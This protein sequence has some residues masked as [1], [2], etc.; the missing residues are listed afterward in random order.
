VQL[1]EAAVAAGVATGYY[2]IWGTWRE[3]PHDTLVAALDALGYAGAPDSVAMAR[4]VEERLNERAERLLPELIVAEAGTAI[5]MTLSPRCAAS[6]GRGTGAGFTCHWQVE[7]EAGGA[8]DG[9]CTVVGDQIELPSL[10][11]GQHR[12]RVRL[13]AA[14]PTEARPGASGAPG[15]DIASCD[16]GLLVAPPRCYLPEFL[17][18]GGRQ[19]GIAVQLYGLRSE[20]NWGIGDLTDLIA[21]IDAAVALGAQVVG[22][23]PLHALAL[24][25]PES[26]SPYSAVSRLFLHPLYIDPERCSGFS[27]PGKVEAICARLAPYPRRAS[28]RQE[29]RVDYAGVSGL[30]LPVLRALFEAFM[31]DEAGSDAAEAFRQFQHG[32]VGL[33]EHATFQSIQ[34]ALNAA[35][36]SVWG[37]PCWP[38]ALQDPGSAQVLAWQRDHAPDIAF[39]M[40][41]EWQARQQWARV[42]EHARAAQVAL[43]G[44]L[45]LGADRGGSEVWAAQA[46]HAL[47]M[48]AGCPPDD[49]NLQGQDWGLPPL[50]PDRLLATGCAPVRAAIRA[51]MAQ[52][53]ALR[54]DHVMSLMR[55]FW[56]PPGN[57]PEGGTYVD[58]P[59]E[60]LLA[61]LR[62]ETECNQCMLIGEDLGTVPPAVREG[63][64]ATDVLSYRLLVFE[65][66]SS[67]RFRAPRA[68]PRLSLASIGS[69]D[70]APL[71]GWWS[72]DDLMQRA[73]IG[74]LD[75][76]QFERFSW[77]RGEARQGL[78]ATLEEEGLLP[79]GETADASRYP[80][81]PAS[82]VD[83]VHAFLSRTESMWAMVNPEDAFDLVEATN[84]PGT[85]S[86]HANWCRKLPVPVEQWARYP[87]LQAIAAR[88]REAR[89]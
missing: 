16:A 55:L 76:V 61:T 24:D 85:T 3:T 66:V 5:R 75:P 21:L 42:R 19:W 8:L 2:D 23:N 81:L 36:T 47:T 50:R 59:F 12:V 77:D 86:E 18:Q 63:L 89:D 9:G 58:Y 64:Q 57:S 22:L 7:L 6:R 28:L 62:I 51:S 43:Y 71:Q 44:D 27:D 68:Y 88:M 35:D 30:K 37:W 14:Q 70:L 15:E 78:L 1:N 4:A 45:A 33:L 73:R 40:F 60:A 11:S 26:A 80:T 49:F 20:R 74:L 83:A 53:D 25:R 46:E 65:R 84:L 13:K 32:T 39:H 31:Q 79:D 10:P 67:T 72:G 34:V 56:I 82:L 87:R 48:S 41:L 52:F 38:Q 54:L 17:V 29:E 69:H